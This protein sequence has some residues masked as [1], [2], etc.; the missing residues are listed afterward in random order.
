MHK[1][2]FRS[3]RCFGV[4][5]VV[6]CDPPRKCTSNKYT[7]E[8]SS[9]RTV[10]NG[11]PWPMIPATTR[12]SQLPV[13]GLSVATSAAVSA[14]A[15]DITFAP[16]GLYS[17]QFPENKRFSTQGRRC[18]A[19]SPRRCSGTEP[20]QPPV[21]VGSGCVPLVPRQWRRKPAMPRQ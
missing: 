12:R 2:I 8:R 18:R 17:G 19:R 4:F 13:Q 14:S 1:E 9:W 5:V 16:Q 7:A 6:L 3:Q 21:V 20:D 15:E 11:D 10:N